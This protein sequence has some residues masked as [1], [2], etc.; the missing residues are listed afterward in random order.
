MADIESGGNGAAIGVHTT[1]LEH[2]AIQVLVEV[3]NSVV[4]RQQHQLRN[5]IRR[6]TACIE[7]SLKPAASYLKQRRGKH[8]TSFVWPEVCDQIDFQK[9]HKKNY[10]VILL[11]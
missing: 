11:R 3:V 2:V 9:C 5:L 10:V 6:D 8:W 1:L 4:E 7:T